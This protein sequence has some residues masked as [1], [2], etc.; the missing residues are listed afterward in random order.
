M[1]HSDEDQGSLL[2]QAPSDAA[3]ASATGT[4][5]VLN[6]CPHCGRKLLSTRSILCNWCGARIDDPV[7]QRKAAEERAELDR[8]VKEQIDRELDET[9]RFG[10]LG[11]LQR[12]K[13][14]GLG[15]R[16]QAGLLLP[17]EDS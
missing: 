5:G 13:K 1:S 8:K 9:A 4:A 15:Q 11:R 17:D 6:E 14:L 7:Y 2:E 10:V 16:T 3:E 12:K